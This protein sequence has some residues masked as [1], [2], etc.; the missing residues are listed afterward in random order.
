MKRKLR[1]LKKA[2]VEQG[3]T[4]RELS[5]VTG[6]SRQALFS[7]EN[8]TYPPRAD[9]WKVLKKV[10]KLKG[11][12]EDYWGRPAHTGTPK[13]YTKDDRCKMPGCKSVPTSIGYCRKHY[14]RVRYRKIHKTAGYS[15]D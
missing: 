2:R 13:I 11:T 9:V 3:L 8:G 1:E 7:Y 14:Q 10:L 12:V 5:E 6:V 15:K 4:Y